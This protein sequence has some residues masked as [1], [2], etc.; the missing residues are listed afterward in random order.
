M[1]YKKKYEEALES[2]K[3]LYDKV[4]WLSSTEALETFLALEKAFPELVENEDG[5]AM[6]LLKKLIDNNEILNKKDTDICYAWLEKQGEHKRFLQKIQIGDQVT[7]NQNGELFNLSQLKRVAKSSEKQKPFEEVDGE[8]YGIDGLWHAERILEKTLG[9]V[10]GYQSDDGILEHKAAITAVRDL[11]KN[12]REQKPAEWSEEDSKWAEEIRLALLYYSND[13]S[14]VEKLTNWFDNHVQSK[15]EWSEEDEKRIER[16][17]SFIWKNRKGDTDEIYQ[18]EQ[19]ANWLKSKLKLLNPHPRW[20]PSED[21]EETKNKCP[22][23]SEGYGCSTSP[24][25]Q[26]DTCPYY[27]LY[28]HWKPTEKQI[29]VLE[30]YL[31]ALSANKDK[32]VLFS[33]YEDIKKL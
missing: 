12:Q 4:R 21:K 9:E 22:N 19:D 3:P 23:Y 30:R 24:L 26:C 33:L 11:A 13:K 18:Q 6:R 8:E 1:D 20:K 10:E 2:V 17:V 15:Q 28:N 5:K 25:N 7:R 29:E 16:I 32:E 27:K 14:L 31:Y